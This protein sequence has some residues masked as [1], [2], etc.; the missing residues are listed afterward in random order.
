MKLFVTPA[1]VPPHA[2]LA[3]ST[4]PPPADLG[5]LLGVEAVAVEQVSALPP[6]EAGR[7]QLVGVAAPGKGGGSVGVALIAVDGQP[8]KAFRVGARVDGE[9]VLQA[10]QMRSAQLGQRGAPP[11]LRLELP[12]PPPAAT[13]TPPGLGAPGVPQAMA[14]PGQPLQPR[15]PG[16]PMP[17]RAQGAAPQ[18]ALPSMPVRA[19]VMPMPM[20]PA[21]PML[22]Q[23][24]EDRGAVGGEATR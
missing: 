21:Q 4:A 19:G 12:P 3:A 2:V 9:V 6:A 22:P 7:Y 10:V 5:R 13:G 23:Q 1:E 24:P 17:H 15:L 11:M 14:A 16:I 18:G 8:A 20:Q